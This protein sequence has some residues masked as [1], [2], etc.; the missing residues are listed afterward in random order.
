MKHLLALAAATLLLG[1]CSQ[2]KLTAGGEKV[3]VLDPSE[4]STCR[5]LGKTTNSVTAKVLLERPANVIAKE[6]E[7]MARNSAS[8]LGGDTVVPLT[9]VENG[10]QTHVVYKCVN[11]GG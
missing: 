7:I 9:I 11:P 1:G 10:E 4:V 8:R 2:I 5:E 3:R 6:L